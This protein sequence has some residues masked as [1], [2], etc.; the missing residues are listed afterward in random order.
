MNGL[1]ATQRA[2]LAMI[3]KQYRHKSARVVTGFYESNLP[4]YEQA[5]AEFGDDRLFIHGRA[6]H[7]EGQLDLSKFWDIFSRIR[8][9]AQ[10]PVLRLATE[11]E[12]AGA[13]SRVGNWLDQHIM[14][15]DSKNT[16]KLA[17]AEVELNEKG[18]TLY[19]C[20]VGK[21]IVVYT[22]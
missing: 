9:E 10:A 21:K 15:G 18:V 20:M 3:R 12:A 7:S 11:I 14:F 17:A 8:A 16:A 6:L 2:A 22:R 4:F 13:L 5:V 19:E 1:D